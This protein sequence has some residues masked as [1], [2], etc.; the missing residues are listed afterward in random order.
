M[1]HKMIIVLSILLCLSGCSTKSDENAVDKTKEHQEESIKTMEINGSI[2]DITSTRI[3]IK[4]TKETISMNRE[5]A[6]IS[7]DLLVGN[8]AHVVYKKQG[9]DMIAI[10][11]QISDETKSDIDEIISNMTLEEK[12]GQMFMVRCPTSKA[13]E[14]IDTY[15]MG[16]YMLFDETISPYTTD[17][18]IANNAAFQ[19]ES[20]ISMLIGVDEEGGSVNRLS[21]YTNYRS[22][23]FESPQSLY[24]KGGF[25]RIIED[26]K[27]KD[28]LLKSLGINVNFAPVSDVS[29]NPSDFIFPRSFGKDANQTSEYVKIVVSTMNEDQIGNVLKHFPGYGNNQD[30]HTGSSID[31]RPYDTFMNQDFLPFE[32]G[33]KA[34]AGSI[35]VSH[36]IIMAVDENN[37]ASLSPKLHEIL[38]QNLQ[39]DGVI[40]TDDLYMDAIRKTRGIEQAA[41]EA[42]EAGNDMLIIRNYKVQIPA[43]LQAVKDG[44]IKEERIN[45]SVKRILLWK[46]Q[47][48]LI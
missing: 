16:G 31:K 37:P 17:Q 18:F 21:W 43:V 39:F 44:T 46:K 3:V 11:I 40:F 12:V 9:D 26:T 6:D 22:Q 27:E 20:K 34:G 23:P 19:K 33:I 42:I 10:Q 36:N 13:L 14:A 29:T 48:G 2:E 45:E 7:G 30:T 25:D 24:Q 8:K 28:A 1:K 47:L 32:A 35:L 5:K 38:R 15:H 41:I 4:S